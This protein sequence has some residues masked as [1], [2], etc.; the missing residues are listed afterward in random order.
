GSDHG[1]WPLRRDSK[2]HD[3]NTELFKFLSRTTGCILGTGREGEATY[4]VIDRAKRCNYADKVFALASH[5][6]VGD[7]VED[8][9]WGRLRA[10]DWDAWA[11]TRGPN[12]AY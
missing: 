3:G 12:R 9:H 5:F 7:H 2:I 8:L 4:D 1:N 11:L 10:C 6:E